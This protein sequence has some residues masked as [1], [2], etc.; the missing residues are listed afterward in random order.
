M[1]A[2]NFL[3][4]STGEGGANAGYWINERFEEIMAEAEHYTDEDQLA[5]LMKEAQT[6][7]TEQDPPGIYYGTGVA[8]VGVPPCPWNGQAP[9]AAPGDAANGGAAAPLSPGTG[10]LRSGYW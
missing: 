8:T 3:E 7:L 6:I 1:L 10:T 5:A 4:A 2:P 9:I